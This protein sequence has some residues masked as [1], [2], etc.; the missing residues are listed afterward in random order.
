LATAG[1]EEEEREGGVGC[2][3]AREGIRPARAAS[4]RDSR[5][6][7]DA[8]RAGVGVGAADDA[9][10]LGRGSK[11]SSIADWRFWRV[12]LDS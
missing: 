11:R 9:S 4:G 5:E 12:A 1:E 6:S 10:P 7:V 3:H 8:A 2:M